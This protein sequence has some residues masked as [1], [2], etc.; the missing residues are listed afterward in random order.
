[1][2]F[3]L[4]GLNLYGFYSILIPVYAFLFIAARVAVSGDYKRFLERVAKIS[5]WPARMRVLPQLRP[6]AVVFSNGI[7]RRPAI[8]PMLG[9]CSSS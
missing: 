8:R 3:M 1:M 6:C 7:T 2:Q 5:I 4:V 9:C